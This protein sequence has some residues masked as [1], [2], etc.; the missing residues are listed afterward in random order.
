MGLLLALLMI[1]Q[2]VLGFVHHRIYKQ[3][4]QTTKLAPM[5]VWLGRLLIIVAVVVAFL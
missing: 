1:A 4:H 2:F 3:T 5:H